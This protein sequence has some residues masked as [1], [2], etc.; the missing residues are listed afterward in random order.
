MGAS[1]SVSAVVNKEISKT[2]VDESCTC[3]AG[4]VNYIGDININLKGCL[5]PGFD[6][7]QTAKAKCNCPVKA[8]IQQ[9][10]TM[11]AKSNSKVKSSLSFALSTN[12][13]DMS[14]SSKIEQD[15][16]QSCSSLSSSQNVIKNFSYTQDCTNMTPQEL[17]E[18]KATKVAIHQTSSAQAACLMTLADKMDQHLTSSQK[19]TTTTTNPIA[20]IMGAFSKN[21]MAFIVVIIVVIVLFKVVSGNQATTP[22]PGAFPPQAVTQIPP[23]HMQQLQQY[24]PPGTVLYDQE[25]G[26]TFMV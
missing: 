14:N 26:Q 23:H 24:H 21:V 13:S 10:A 18:N 1:T 22:P 4:N 9:L 11:A 5:N 16:T 6:F 19:Q 15:L 8:A 25:S 20:S 17:E 12:V 3:S 7:D 2:N